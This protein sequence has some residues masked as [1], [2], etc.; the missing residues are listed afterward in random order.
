MGNCANKPLTTEGEAPAPEQKNVDETTREIQI[1]Q[2]KV[3]F[4]FSFKH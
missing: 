3:K 2:N 4:I 1:D